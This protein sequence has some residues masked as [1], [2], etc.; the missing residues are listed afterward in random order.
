[1]RRSGAP[2]SR[3]ECLTCDVAIDEWGSVRVKRLYLWICFEVLTLKTVEQA[4][5]MHGQQQEQHLPE[6]WKGLF[7]SLWKRRC[8]WLPGQ[9]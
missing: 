6:G 8:C 4:L 5:A 9:G 3:F 1:M 7:S 2:S